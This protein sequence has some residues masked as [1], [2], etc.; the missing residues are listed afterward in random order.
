MNFLIHPIPV[1]FEGGKRWCAESGETS[2]FP[3]P[4]YTATVSFSYPCILP[5]IETFL[6]CFL[7]EKT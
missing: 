7:K 1:G 3:S 6:E 2:A 4:A 5:S